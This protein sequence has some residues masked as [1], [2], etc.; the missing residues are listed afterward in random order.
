MLLTAFFFTVQASIHPF[1]HVLANLPGT[2]GLP[3]AITQSPSIAQP[4]V[5]L[6]GLVSCPRTLPQA[7]MQDAGI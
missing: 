6:W 4:P 7:N 3:G 2:S 5:A 1:A